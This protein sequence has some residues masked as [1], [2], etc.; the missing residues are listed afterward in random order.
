MSA[1]PEPGPGLGDELSAALRALRRSLEG[2]PSSHDEV[3]ERLRAVD[4]RVE[5]ELTAQR[6]RI[7]DLGDS[8]NLVERWE[9]A[10]QR[11]RAS[12]RPLLGERAPTGATAEDSLGRA[13]ATALERDSAV[14]R[15]VL[16]C[17]PLSQAAPGAAELPDDPSVTPSYADPEADPA[18]SEDLEGGPEAP[19]SEAI[20]AQAEALDWDYVRIFEFVRNE[21]ET[22]WYAGSQKGAE[23]TL[24]QRA[25]NDV[26]QA[27]LLLALCRASQLPG[28][29][30]HGVVELPV[31][32]IASTLGITGSDEVLK[33]LARAGVAHR[34]VVEGGQI[35]AVEVE[36]T[37]V[38]VFAPYAN[39]RGAVVD[40]SGRSWIPLAPALTEVE[41]VPATGVLEEMGLDVGQLVEEHLAGDRDRLPL[42]RLRTTV[43]SFLA[44]G[45]GGTYAD[46]LARRS[47]VE[48]RAQLLPSTLPARVVTVFEETAT[49]PEQ[50]LTTLRLVARDGPS[51]T[52]SV[53]FD[54]TY[55]LAELVGRRVTLSYTPATV[56][57][58]EIVNA[59]GGMASV[60]CYL[61]ELRLQLKVD[62]RL[63]QAGE[64]VLDMGTPHRLE[65]IL[66]GPSGS[67]TAVRT[68]TSGSYYAVELAAAEPEPWSDGG[69]D[70]ADTEGLAARLLARIGRDHASR[71]TAA[72]R[73]LADLMGL[74]LV[75]PLP[76]LA[77]VDDVVGIE[78]L[79][80]LPY[81]LSW[82]GVT[83]D[84]VARSAEPVGADTELEASWLEL[85]ALQGSAL[86]HRVFADDYLVDAI[87]ADRALGLARDE[88]VDV[89]RL[90]STTLPSALPGLPHAPAV[91]EALQEAVAQGYEV[92]ISE[93]LTT[94]AAWS[95]S[96][97]RVIDPDGLGAGYLLSG[98]LAGG[99][100]TE[101]PGS[102]ILSFLEAALAQPYAGGVNLDP[103]AGVSVHRIPETDEQRESSGRSWRRPGLDR[104]RRA[105]SPGR[106][107]RG[108]L[109]NGGRRGHPG[110]RG[111]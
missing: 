59:Y 37:W 10:R 29:Y 50:M 26:D 90:D 93:A 81:R 95:G 79:A 15:P 63:R 110:E 107:C 46:Q 44:S 47:V 98:G 88:G 48:Q 80:G 75:R 77:V 89:L 1:R 70:P 38:T 33:A 65:M 42:E 69:S 32:R 82:E 68:L 83:L 14:P 7:H 96:G 28:R 22:E 4:R 43:E 34:P 2:S 12:I 56:E 87:S 19:L 24:R 52:A 21:I 31:G 5:A 53:V 61:V 84:A 108:D 45:A 67:E 30:V 9:E 94:R 35:V 76:A 64:G 23:E 71:W 41:S 92:E 111:G 3:L 62:G 13:L 55:P 6:R 97:W 11:Y 39:Y 20:L 86:E 27:S 25:G 73:E 16:E 54:R 60:P 8:P 78:T 51:S 40:L 109:R 105:G 17:A 74:G 102:W 103:L 18:V 104:A 100:T 57:D 49:L 58:H 72:E 91:K 101:A 85:A 66:S 99:S 36:Q 106:G